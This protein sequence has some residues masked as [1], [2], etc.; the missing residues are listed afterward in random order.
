MAATSADT[1][2][3][4]AQEW[5]RAPA[6][7]RGAIPEDLRVGALEGIL[8]VALDLCAADSG[9]LMVVD[10]EGRELRVIVSRG[11]KM[12]PA[13]TP[14]I[15]LGDRIAGRVA[16]TG[17]PLLLRS[18]GGDPQLAS[19]LTRRDEIRTAACVPGQAA[20]AV[21]AVLTVNQRWNGAEPPSAQRPQMDE[22]ALRR[23]Q[24]LADYIARDLARPV[25][26]APS[27][28]ADP[29]T[30]VRLDRLA[31]LGLVAGGIA[32]EINNPL[33]GALGLAEL[34][35]LQHETL[36]PAQRTSQLTSLETELYRLA[37]I[38]ASLL[39]FVR[40][41]A[42]DPRAVADP[43]ACLEFAV[44]SALAQNPAADIQ[45]RRSYCPGLPPVR[46]SPAHLRQVLLNLVINA[47][48]AMGDRGELHLGLTKSPDGPFLLV[49]V[50]DTGPG[51]APQDLNRIFEPGFTTKPE[52][53]GTGLGL[54]VSR[55][56]VRENGGDLTVASRPGA[57]ATF[58]VE[59]PL[60]DLERSAAR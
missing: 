4:Q 54:A 35:L 39:S 52:G 45:C 28:V 40:E 37:D 24:V 2:R 36:S 59:L 58:T 46:L 56:L 32:H 12:T 19:L 48:Q 10:H 42:N 20:G 8:E 33:Q 14:R 41:G 31:N 21:E 53:H 26:P 47:M 22:N 34:L 29:Q 6:G 16:E 7:D 25:P 3:P 55:N 49:V 13:E 1:G 38:V 5:Q 17:T 50:G 18:E 9:S 23:L 11:L 57:G 30:Q 60:A 27:L 15:K 44:R 51:I 43:I